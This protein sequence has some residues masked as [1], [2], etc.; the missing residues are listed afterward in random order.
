MRSKAFLKTVTGTICLF[1]LMIVSFESCDDGSVKIGVN[2][3]SQKD[4]VNATS[5]RTQFAEINGRKILKRCARILTT[6]KRES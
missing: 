4:E 5:S 3:P 2:N 1:L 6:L